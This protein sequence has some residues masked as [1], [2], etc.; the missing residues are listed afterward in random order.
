MSRQN[1]SSTISKKKSMEKFSNGARSDL[2]LPMIREAESNL[3][4]SRDSNNVRSMV[5]RINRMSDM[6]QPASPIDQRDFIFAS[7]DKRASD[8]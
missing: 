7:G 2:K 4:G 6:K 3:R 1:A 8:L 5:N